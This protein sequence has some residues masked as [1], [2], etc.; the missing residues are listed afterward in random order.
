MKLSDRS[1][2]MFKQLLASNLDE[3][4]A[5]ARLA[6]LDPQSD[7]INA[8]LSGIDFGARD[9]NG[10]IFAGANLSNAD[11]SRAKIDGASFF[12]AIVD[13]V[14][15]PDGPNTGQLSNRIETNPTNEIAIGSV[16][17]GIVRRIVNYGVF[18]EI[19][20]DVGLLH[21]NDMSWR[22]FRHPS[23]V[24]ALGQHVTVKILHIDETTGH[25]ALTNEGLVEDPWQHIESKYSVGDHISAEIT[26]IEPFGIFVALEP[27]LTGLIHRSEV[28][29]DDDR[30]RMNRGDRITV[31]IISI[32]TDE[33]KISLSARQ[34]TRDPLDIFLEANPPG[35][36]VQAVVRQRTDYAI[37]VHIFGNLRGIVHYSEIDGGKLGKA[38][39]KRYSSGR[40]L[41]V[42][43][44]RADYEKRR[45]VLSHSMTSEPSRAA[46]S[47]KK[48]DI[49]KCQVLRVRRNIL[50]IGVVGDLDLKVEIDFNLLQDRLRRRVGSNLEVGSELR[51]FVQSYD[52]D[53]RRIRLVLDERLLL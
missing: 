13:G 17:D 7:F 45:I 3:F 33:R 35:S 20:S 15:W 41:A 46:R 42:K 6:K 22:D 24:L 8:D 5:L 30:P 19:G 34:T 50:E 29:W 16:V 47:F 1:K 14:R 44:L 40:K 18:V 51:A 48:G 43:V 23:E 37:F 39:L 27:G 53:A 32:D 49:V 25:L 21:K 12:G 2:D 28:A 11:F 26:K 4:Y 10:W 38:A 31:A 52:K 36:I 9:Y